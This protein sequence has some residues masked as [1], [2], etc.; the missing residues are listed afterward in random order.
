MEPAIDSVKSNS[1]PPCDRRWSEIC[2]RSKARLEREV[3]SVYIRA[4]MKADPDR[5]NP[6]F[7]FLRR[8]Q[9]GGRSNMYGAV[10][11]LMSRFSLDRETAFAIV[12]EWLDQQA[13]PEPEA[14]HLYQGERSARVTR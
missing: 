2:R 13:V 12:C 4:P 10:P 8:L 3:I 1:K 6:F 5:R 7:R 9:A 11:Y 14:P